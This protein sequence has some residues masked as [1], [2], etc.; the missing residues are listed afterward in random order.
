MAKRT[1][2]PAPIHGETTPRFAAVREAFSR[3]F[4]ERDELGAACAIYHRGEKVVDLWGGYSD[5]ARRRPWEQ[6]TLVLVFSTTKGMAAMALAVAHSQGLLE[7][8]APVAR[9][10]PE[11]AQNGKERVTVR[12]LLSHQ[13]GIP[14]IEPPLD[15]AT[16]ADLDRLAA[17]LARQRPEW[18][19]GTRHGYHGLALG[20]YEGELLRRVD[21]R[22]RSLGQFFQD[23]V[24]GPLG[25]EFYIGVPKNIPDERIAEIK[26]YSPLRLLL[27]L[28]EMPWPF[29]KALLTPGSLAVRTAR[30]HGIPTPAVA[31]SPS[32]R[33]IEMPAANGIGQVRAIAR[34][35]GAFASGGR[36]LGLKPE[37]LAALT[38]PAQPPSEGTLDAVLH[39]ETSYS[40]GYLK[41]FPKLRFGGARAFGT[42]GYGGSFGFADLDAE[43]GFAYA[44]N[45][46]GYHLW[47]D[48]RERALRD[49]VYACIGAASRPLPL[50]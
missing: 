8:D 40:L 41:P 39:V 27:H 34:A 31:G 3:N 20:C 12:Q 14:A 18:V 48:P 45:R 29:V 2:N 13:A 16:L 25:I 46:C 24:A 33:S 7:Y 43:L 10:W 35:Y 9:Y 4:S 6:D 5:L 22:R 15:V 23:E 47:D 32:L 21:P 30:V 1:P 49:A 28:A 19:P 42:P 17:L 38:A 26:E 44:P 36:E 11:F 37:T 50:Q